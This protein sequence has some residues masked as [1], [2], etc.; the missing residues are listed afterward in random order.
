MHV[1]NE[2][3]NSENERSTN[4]V[5]TQSENSITV[6]NADKPSVENKQ[7]DTQS[8]QLD[9]SE[10]NPLDDRVEKARAEQSQEEEKRQEEIANKAMEKVA[11]KIITAISPQ[12][13]EQEDMR[14]PWE[15][16]NRAPTKDELDS[17]FDSRLEQR[18]QAETQQVAT[19]QQELER[20]RQEFNNRIDAELAT[21]RKNGKL[22]E[23]KDPNNPN[24][25]GR[26]AER[27]LLEAALNNKTSSMY[28]AYAIHF[29]WDK[30]PAGADAPIGGMT[31]GDVGS[32]ADSYSYEDIHGS[33]FNKI[34]HAE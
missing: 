2:D 28:E 24:D 23:I 25:P 21:L 11:D 34:A 30:Q 8:E 10:S 22:P 31:G 1:E 16:E 15:K 17:Y 13:E 20:Q 9:Q 3:L 12:K 18:L 7:T 32:S 19:Q 4:Q 26:M 5:E 29:N 33:S 14:S 27:Q 6:N